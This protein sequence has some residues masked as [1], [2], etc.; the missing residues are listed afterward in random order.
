MS[1]A[2][3]SPQW[4]YGYDVVLE[5][6]FSIITL[7]VAVF[8]FKIYKKTSQEQV[9]LF[10][11]SFLLISL[12]YLFQSIF[13]FLTI[14]KLT[15]AICTAVKISSVNTFNTFG[16]ITHIFLMTTGLTILV[17]TTFKAKNL[18]LLSF[19]IITSL[20][21]IILSRNML[22]TFFLLSTIYLVFIEWHFIKNYLNNKKTKTLLVALAFL[23][24]LFGNF[25]FLISVNHQVYY[26]VGHILELFAYLFILANLYMVLKK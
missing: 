26:A 24:L 11:V 10:G 25:H 22:Y 17:Y 19:L 20:V 12:S 18:K 14:A 8:A 2:H 13:N 21:S 16:I 6:L 15:Q 23:F 3:L 7:I 4:F 5:L 1:F 9:R